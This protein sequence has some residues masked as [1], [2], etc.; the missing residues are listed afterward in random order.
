MIAAPARCVSGLFDYNAQS[1]L[2]YLKVPTQAVP[3]P[4]IE[5]RIE[6]YER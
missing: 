3:T 4:G 6:T 1:R 5:S 2:A